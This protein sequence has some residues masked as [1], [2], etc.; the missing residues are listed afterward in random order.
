[1]DS[2][3]AQYWVITF[4]AVFIW[5]SD[6]MDNVLY[7][8]LHIESRLHPPT[9]WIHPYRY[10]PLKDWFAVKGLANNNIRKSAMHANSEYWKAHLK[11]TKGY[12]TKLFT[13]QVS[14]QEL[15]RYYCK[16]SISI[17]SFLHK[18][19]WVTQVLE[20]IH[21]YWLIWEYQFFF[22]DTKIFLKIPVE[23]KLDL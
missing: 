11:K 4:S 16:K 23:M 21:Y 14:I 15:P 10:L 18:F 9:R 19:R 17:L 8:Y 2:L 6:Y 22:K 1:M 3:Q 13:W 20:A 7:S 5:L 12:F